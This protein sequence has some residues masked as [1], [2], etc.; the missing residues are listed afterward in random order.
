MDVMIGI[1]YKAV[2]ENNVKLIEEIFNR[3]H[4]SLKDITDK[5]HNERFLFRA[6]EQNYQAMVS[7]LVKNGANV[8]S[9]ETVDMSPLLLAIG[10]GNV[11]MTELLIDLGSNIGEGRVNQKVVCP[12]HFAVVC[13][14]LEIVLLL[15]AKGAN[16]DARDVF[17]NETALNLVSNYD[18]IYTS[19]EDKKQKMKI[20]VKIAQALLDKGAAVDSR[21]SI[22]QNPVECALIKRNTELCKLL[23]LEGASVKN[24]KLDG[25]Y[26]EF[27]RFV[28][29]YPSTQLT[30]LCLERGCDYGRR[31]EGS[32]TP[33]HDALLFSKPDVVKVFLEFSCPFDLPAIVEGT[34][35]FLNFFRP[36]DENLPVL[37]IQK[38]FIEGIKNNSL[39]SVKAA[40]YQGAEPKGCSMDVPSTLHYVVE[41]GNHE[42]IE[43]LLKKGVPVNRVNIEGE[44]PLFIAVKNKNVQA[45]EIL[46]KFGA[47]IYFD[48]KNSLKQ[49]FENCDKLQKLFEAINNCFKLVKRGNK[50]V[51]KLVQSYNLSNKNNIMLSVLL[52]C[53]NREGLS[54]MAMALQMG[55]TEI[56]ENLMKLRI[57]KL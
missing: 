2:M 24:C 43:L 21:N 39:Q 38:K 18:Y 54:L 8:N 15:L 41:N 33:Y 52:N 31:D 35:N 10:Q 47:C 12:L 48:K 5:K 30:R 1:I 19:E 55:H 44:T 49:V 23:F 22:G 17:H 46:L 53:V 13:L 9:C 6:V 20:Q 51:L 14:N 4:I 28:A 25:T 36:N 34:A 11:K 56:A 37:A 27:L 40:L 42:L 32:L 50:R 57:E 7:F 26:Y 29:V 3:H 16:V 45:S